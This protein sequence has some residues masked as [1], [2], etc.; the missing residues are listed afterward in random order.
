MAIYEDRIKKKIINRQ[1]LV[2]KESFEN[3]TQPVDGLYISIEDALEI[4][5]KTAEEALADSL[6][7]IYLVCSV[8]KQTSS[9][10]PENWATAAFVSETDALQ[11]KKHIEA[12]RVNIPIGDMTG[13]HVLELMLKDNDI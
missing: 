11:L 9:N 13:V 12:T 4:A 2:S 8:Y 6:K 7:K 3:G 10:S 5:R 1:V